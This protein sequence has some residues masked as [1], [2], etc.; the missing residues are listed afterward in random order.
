MLYGAGPFEGFY[1]VARQYFQ[2][3]QSLAFQ[4]QCVPCH[5]FPKVVKPVNINPE[6]FEQDV[7]D[8]GGYI[9]AGI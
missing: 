3:I 8:F 4:L 6:D 9:T 2:R 5:V 7:Q 1:C